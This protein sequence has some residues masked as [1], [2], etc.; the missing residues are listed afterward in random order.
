MMH[1]F[2][3]SA[4]SNKNSLTVKLCEVPYESIQEAHIKI[5]GQEWENISIKNNKNLEYTFKH[6]EPDKVYEIR[7]EIKVNDVWVEVQGAAF[8]TYDKPQNVPKH[9]KSGKGVLGV[10]ARKITAKS[11]KAVDVNG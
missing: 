8:K 5:L 4:K 11:I 2:Y 10:S 7:A 9:I 3:D 1:V 6:L